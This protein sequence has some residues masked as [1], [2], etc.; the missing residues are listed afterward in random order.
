MT[1]Q[2]IVAELRKQARVYARNVEQFDDHNPYHADPIAWW[3]SRA[4]LMTAAADYIE[5]AERK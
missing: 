5:H 4:D 3:Q 2:Q 1:P